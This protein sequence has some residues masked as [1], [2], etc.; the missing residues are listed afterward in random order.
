MRAKVSKW[1]NSLGIRIPRGL[2][3]DA[4]LAE[5]TQVDLRVENGRIVAEPVEAESLDDLLARVTPENCHGEQFADK[6]IG[7]ERW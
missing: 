7:R 5:G 4:N 6:P 2:A 1:G 3:E